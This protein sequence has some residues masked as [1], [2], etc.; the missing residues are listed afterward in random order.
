MA[1]P[2]AVQASAV[3]TTINNKITEIKSSIAELQTQLKHWEKVASDYETNKVT[4][5]SILSVH[6]APDVSAPKTK[7]RLT[8]KGLDA[9]K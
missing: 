3:E 6:N 1:R 5:E 8:A 4:I 7:R 9:I 2:K